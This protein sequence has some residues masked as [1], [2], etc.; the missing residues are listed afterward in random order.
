MTRNWIDD[1]M[2]ATLE[3]E[4][5]RSFVRW[6]ALCAISAVMTDRVY[7]DKHY[8]KL[9]PN[10]Y[11]LL[12]AK[13]GLRKSFP[14]MLAKALVKVVDN[15]RVISGRN[16]IQAIIH[17]LST[18][19]TKPKQSPLVKAHGF[20][21]T[22]ELS[23]TFIE[24]PQTL[25]ILMDLYD[26]HYH[27]DG[28]DYTLKG[29]GKESLKDIAVTLLG[30]INPPHF[31]DMVHSK[32]ITGGFIARTII[33]E[34]SR[35]ALKNPLIDAPKQRLDTAELVRYLVEL[36]KVEGE[37]KWS[38]D[39]AEFYREWYKT[40]NP[41]DMED[42]TGTAN[43][44]HDQIL[45]VAMLL[46]LARDTELIYLKEDI[47]E[48]MDLLESAIKTA[49]SATRGHGESD[50][51]PKVRIVLEEL[52]SSPDH[53]V[54]RSELLIKHWGDFTAAELSI[55]IQTLE[56]AKAVTARTVGKDELYTATDT[57]LDVIEAFKGGIH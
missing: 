5:P 28:W 10:I 51:S 32:D 3:A 46:S 35:R 45:K 6:A 16:S 22:G 17:E 15:T 13:S 47:Q 24:D 42:D 49:A 9:F 8:Y 57:L 1:V 44:I 50:F 26:G 53:K 25:T 52:E 7:L 20:I 30:A 43:R 56:G 29:T 54:K 21:V 18:T 38:D 37:F 55:V 33:V 2:D 27:Q 31:K 48:A 40:F 11:V 41:E 14:P 39:A 19:V 12:V 34:E 4:S 23:T 36:S